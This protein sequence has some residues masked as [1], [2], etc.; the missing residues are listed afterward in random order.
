M[1]VLLSIPHVQETYFVKHQL[2]IQNCFEF[3]ADCFHCQMGK[4]ADGLLSGRYSVA[5]IDDKNETRGQDGITPSMF[6]SIVGKGHP[7]FSTMRQQDAQ[8]FLQHTLSLMQQKERVMGTDSTKACTFQMQSR[9]QCLE[10]ERVQ[11][12]SVPSTSLILPVP[13]V[14]KGQTDD[15][16]PAYEPV[17]LLEMIETYFD[18]DMREYNCPIDNSKTTATVASTFKSFPEYLFFV[19]SRFVLGEGWVM[20]KLNVEIQTPMEISLDHLRGQGIQEGEVEFPSDSN[21]SDEPQFNPDFLNQLMGMGFPENR[22]KK[23]LLKTG[24]SG[25]EPAMN[26]LFEHMDDPDI[27]DPIA[28]S[29]TGTSVSDAELAPL[30]DMGFTRN[31]ALRAMKETNNNMERAVDWLFSHPEVGD[32]PVPEE[33]DEEEKPDT[34]PAKYRLFALISHKGTSAQCGH[35]VAYIRKGNDWVLFNDNKVVQVPDIAEA[36]QGAYVYVFQRNE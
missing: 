2:H 13:A 8:E 15:G 3:P 30:M 1:Q 25:A 14:K 28:V 17:R 7:E 23:A 35:Y 16:K 36:A 12:R 4:L 24:N 18:A 27:D 5:L 20:E 33:Q 21:Q 32:D 29:G 19:A 22:C 6:K 26:W 31:Q 11:Y 9:L 10:C 34:R